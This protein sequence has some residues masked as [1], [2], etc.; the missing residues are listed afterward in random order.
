M[1]SEESQEFGDWPE[2][3]VSIDLV[4]SNVFALLSNILA[5]EQAIDDGIL[6]V[7]NTWAQVISTL[8]RRGEESLAAFLDP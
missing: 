8:H 2:E 7:V 1:I 3:V 4:K 5:S 6:L